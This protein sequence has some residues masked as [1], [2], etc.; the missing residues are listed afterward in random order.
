M[1]SLIDNSAAAGPM[2]L[3]PQTQAATADLAA[4]SVTGSYLMAL[5]DINYDYMDG[6]NPITTDLYPKA[7]Y[8]DATN[9]SYAWIAVP[10]SIDWQAGYKY[11]YTLN[12]SN[13]GCGK[14]APGATS[15]TEGK[16]AGEAIV[17][18]INTPVSFLVTVESEWTEQS[19]TPTM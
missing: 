16:D 3:I 6:N 7:S 5:V 14:A 9:G 1:P 10:V 17:T 12:F 13:T 18:E 15:A 11:T 19:V 8:D 4:A 2:L